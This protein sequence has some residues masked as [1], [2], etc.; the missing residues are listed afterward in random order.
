MRQAS[1]ACWFCGHHDFYI[2]FSFWIWFKASR[3]VVAGDLRAKCF[4]HDL[5]LA[6]VLLTFFFFADDNE[7]G[8]VRLD[9]MH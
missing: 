7:G 3:L 9:I 2:L 6:F 8:E 4:H 1:V 5:L